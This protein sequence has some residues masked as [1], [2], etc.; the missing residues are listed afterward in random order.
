MINQ[1]QGI[2]NLLLV[3]RWIDDGEEVRAVSG[4]AEE[5]VA[6]GVAGGIEGGVQMGEEVAFIGAIQNRSFIE[7]HTGWSSYEPGMASG[8]LGIF[9]VAIGRFKVILVGSDQSG[10]DLIRSRD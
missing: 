7:R 2:F 6:D 5:A 1:G 8:A 4:D 3:K 9:E 10:S